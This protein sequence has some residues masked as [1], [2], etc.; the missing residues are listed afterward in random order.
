MERAMGLPEILGY[1]VFGVRI[2]HR[3][4]SLYKQNAAGAVA[5]KIYL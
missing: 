3:K 2:E 1:C 5:A 4:G